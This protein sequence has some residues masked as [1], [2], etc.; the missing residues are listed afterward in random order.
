MKNGDEIFCPRCGGNSIAREETVMD[1]FTPAGSV[2]VCAVCGAEVGKPE[3]EKP[4]AGDEQDEALRRFA[5]L[6]GEDVPEARPMEYDDSC[7]GF[8]RDCANFVVHPFTPRCSLTAEPAD[9]NG[10][11]EKFRRRGSDSAET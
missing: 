3:T 9:P 6:L 4:G 2:L 5:A 11:C 1:G 10:D 7:G 8:C